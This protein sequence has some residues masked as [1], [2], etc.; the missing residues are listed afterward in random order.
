MHLTRPCEALPDRYGTLSHRLPKALKA[1]ITSLGGAPLLE[2]PV[3]ERRYPERPVGNGLR[4][5]TCRSAQGK[6]F[7]LVSLG[8]DRAP[9]GSRGEDDADITN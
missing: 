6:D 4:S 1:L 3:H 5:I 9:G 2:G 8:R 7:D